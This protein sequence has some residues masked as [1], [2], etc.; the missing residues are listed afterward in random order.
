MLWYRINIAITKQTAVKPKLNF[1]AHYDTIH[2]NSFYTI[3]YVY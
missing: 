2:E 1:I 3:K